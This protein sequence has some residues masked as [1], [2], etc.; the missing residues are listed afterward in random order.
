MSARVL[1]IAA[2]LLTLTIAASGLAVA[3]VRAEALETEDGPSRRSD[4]RARRIPPADATLATAIVPGSVGRSSL[5][6]DATYDASLR[7]SWGTRKISVDSTATIRN[8]SGAPIDRIELNTIAA[9]L[10][11]IQL[12]SVTVDGVAVP[13][14]RSDQTIVVPLGGILPVDATTQIRVRFHA[15]LRS[16][17]SGSNWLFTKTNGIIDLYRWL[18]WVSR[19]IAFDRPNHGDPFE[20]PTSRS[21]RVKI[22][23]VTQ[24][25]P[26]HQRRPDR[27][28]RRRPDPDVRG[29][30]RARFHGH[31]RDR[32]PHQV[33]GRPRF[34]R[35]RL[36]PAR[37]AGGGDARC[38]GG[39][40]RRPRATARVVPASDLPGGPVGRGLRDGVAGSHLDPDRCGRREPAL[41]GR[42]RDRP[43]VVL[44]DRRQRPVEAAVRRRGRRRF[45]GPLHPGL[46]ARQPMRHGDPRSHD[47]PVLG[48]LLLREDLHPGRQPARQRAAE[49]GLDRVLGRAARLHRRQSGQDLDDADACSRRSMRRRRSTSARRCSRRGSR[50]STEGRTGGTP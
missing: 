9:R 11:S 39:R 15:T 17:L 22:T 34:D 1:S 5:F 24:A 44:R 26:G 16:S 19:K 43:P 2:A 6:V 4:R 48:R 32:L 38:R 12:H 3:P 33:A 30:G 7:I 42:P 31:G 27:G 45:R 21:V 47:L 28:Q 49:D 35:A 13:A 46:E 40:L 8:T 37:S 41:P 20:T 29:H 25:R 18:P 50:A 14:T 10:G 36:L 23:T